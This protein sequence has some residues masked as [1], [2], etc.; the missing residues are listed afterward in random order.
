M[1]HELERS[2]DCDHPRSCVK[3][4]GNQWASCT[5]CV[6]CE[7]RL[8]YVPAAIRDQEKKEPGGIMATRPREIR[9]DTFAEDLDRMEA[10]AKKVITRRKV[11]SKGRKEQ[12][13]DEEAKVS[14]NLESSI[15]GVKAVQEQMIEMVQHTVQAMATTQLQLVRCSVT[16]RSRQHRCNDKPRA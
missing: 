8:T 7:A 11:L 14:A 6:K 2:L 4:G 5:K 10:A 1:Y 16:A 3:S 12:E 9:P 15:T 13:T